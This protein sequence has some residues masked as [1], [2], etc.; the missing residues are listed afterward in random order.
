MQSLFASSTILL[1]NNP[2]APVTN[3]LLLRP[4]IFFIQLITLI[5]LRYRSI[6]M[7]NNSFV[8]LEGENVTNVTVLCVC[9][10]FLRKKEWRLAFLRISSP[11]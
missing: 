9:E 11:L 5:T 1:P 3:N 7:F 4:T 2:L 10:T 8:Y 6:K